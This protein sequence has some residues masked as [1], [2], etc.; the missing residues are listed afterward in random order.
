MVH[1][2]LIKLMLHIKLPIVQVFMLMQLLLLQTPVV[3]QQIHGQEVLP[4]AH[5][6]MQIVHM[7][8]Q[9]LAVQIHGQEV[10][11]TVHQV[12]LMVLLLQLILP[13]KKV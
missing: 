2:Y 1:L 5:Q 9:I 13:I 8:R 4:T 12:M 10:L 7:H 6:V 11:L 3:L